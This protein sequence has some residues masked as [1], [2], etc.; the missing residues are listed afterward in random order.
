MNVEK[1]IYYNTEQ[2]KELYEKKKKAMACYEPNRQFGGVRF[3]L[4]RRTEVVLQVRFLSVNGSA[5]YYLDGLCMGVCAK[6]FFRAVLTLDKGE[7]IFDLDIYY[8]HGGFC[9]SAE[10][11]GLVQG[12]S[13]ADRVGG[14]SEGS[15]CVVYLR[16]GDRTLIRFLYSGGTIMK[17]GITDS[18]LWD[19]AVL[20]DRAEGSYLD[21]ACFV[22]AGSSDDLTVE[23]GVTQ[24][25]SLPGL[26]SAA[27]CDARTLEAGADYLVAYTNASGELHLLETVQGQAYSAISDVMLSE[28]VRRVVSAQKG[29]VLFA[30]DKEGIWKAYYFHAN[31]EKS[32]VYPAHTFHYSVIPL[33]KNHACAPDATVDDS[34]GTPVFYYRKE[35]GRLLRCSYGG[36]PVTVSYAEAYHPVTGGGLLQSEG[37]MK[38]YVL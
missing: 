36:T 37:E 28:G 19:K 30:E 8:V 13:Y 21:N 25:L 35:D 34:D 16:N 23:N 24:V 32:L 10:G 26:V 38:Y 2:L 3:F 31:G 14:C 12:E 29:S 27:V 11:A 33:G 7:H 15:D 17:T 22:H 5:E 6:P 1:Q 20:Y 4:R 18:R 9:I